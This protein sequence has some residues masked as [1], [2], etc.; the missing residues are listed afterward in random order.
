MVKTPAGARGGR[1]VSSIPGLGRPSG[2]GHG[3]PLSIL[4]W[5]IPRTE[6][7]GGPPSAGSQRRTRMKRLST[8]AV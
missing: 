3:N 7:P 4:A 2:G 8:R 6:K 1:D 5:R